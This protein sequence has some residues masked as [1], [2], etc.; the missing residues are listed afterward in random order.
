MQ[1]T[2]HR[3]PDL[4]ISNANTLL[5]L[6]NSFK[7]KEKPKKLAYSEELQ[8]LKTE[9]PNV[10][11][12]ATRRTP[13]QKEKEVGRWKLIEDELVARDLPVTGSRWRESKPQVGL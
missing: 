1:L 9:I 7:A 12:H 11:V 10:A 13:I 6:H 3:I 5:D 2:G 8:R 4:V